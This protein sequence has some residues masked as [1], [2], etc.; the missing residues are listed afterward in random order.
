MQLLEIFEVLTAEGKFDGSILRTLL[1][2]VVDNGGASQRLESGLVDHREFEI[3]G[4]RAE[5]GGVLINSGGD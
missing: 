4:R 1:R 5:A 2:L 3:I